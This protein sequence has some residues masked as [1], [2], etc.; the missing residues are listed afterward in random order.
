MLKI[1]TV[2]FVHFTKSKT[3]GQEI[4]EIQGNYFW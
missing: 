4:Q 3:S 2:S 1:K